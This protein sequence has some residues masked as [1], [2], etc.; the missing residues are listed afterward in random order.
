LC[1]YCFCQGGLPLRE[2][3]LWKT[4]LV[5]AFGY[6]QLSAF[7][8][9][10]R[11]GLWLESGGSSSS[12]SSAGGDLASMSMSMG[13]GLGNHITNMS[14]GV[15]SAVSAVAPLPRVV[16]GV[17]GGGSGQGFRSMAKKLNLVPAINAND[18][19]AATS[20]VDLQVWDCSINY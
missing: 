19:A 11:C 17:G 5:H 7:A 6:E 4:R 16:V 2:A 12:S 10:K 8:D 3:K 13:S 14:S 18:A 1:L 15:L 9:L 20:G